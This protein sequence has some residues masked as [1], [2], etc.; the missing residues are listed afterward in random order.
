MPQLQMNRPKPQVM[1]IKQTW[2]TFNRGMA[3]DIEDNDMLMVD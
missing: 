2:I 3:G 1:E